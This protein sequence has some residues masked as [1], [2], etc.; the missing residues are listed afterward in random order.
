VEY[1]VRAIV[2]LCYVLIVAIII[3][4]LL[5][6]FPVNRDNF[7][8][9]LVQTITEPILAPLRRIIPRLD[10]IDL[11]PMVAIILLYVITWVLEPY[12]G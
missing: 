4:S 1:F 2:I 5:S 12:A 9:N 10:M 6:W 8:V 11:S 3:R 7:L